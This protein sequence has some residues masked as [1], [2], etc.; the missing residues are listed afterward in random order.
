MFAPTVGESSEPVVGFRRARHAP[1][2]R[3]VATDGPRAIRYALFPCPRSA[4]PV[5][6]VAQAR[7]QAD[8]PSHFLLARPASQCRL[9]DLWT[10]AWGLC[11]AFFSCLVPSSGTRAV[12]IWRHVTLEPVFLALRGL[13][14]GVA[15]GVHRCPSLNRRLLRVV[16]RGARVASAPWQCQQVDLPGGR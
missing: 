12:R 5:L 6:R 16:S 10:A 1:V 9:R 2:G 15:Q 3:P 14:P 8:V 7:L 13:L 11:V 4:D